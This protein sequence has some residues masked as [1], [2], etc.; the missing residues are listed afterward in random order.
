MNLFDT[1]GL[2]GKD[3][4]EID[5]FASQTD[6][7]AAGD[8]DGFVVEWIV[9]VLQPDV[10]TRGRLVDLR[11][12]RKRLLLLAVAF[13]ALSLAAPQRASAMF[14]QCPPGVKCNQ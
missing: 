7:A 8:H 11:N 12:V 14:P 1:D 3:L 5:F 2:S 4:A 13:L 10:G 9:E 6:T